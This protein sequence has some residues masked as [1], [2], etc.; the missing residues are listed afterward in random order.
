MV[1]PQKSRYSS[2][3]PQG[4]APGVILIDFEQRMLL[5]IPPEGCCV[6]VDLPHCAGIIVLILIIALL[7]RTVLRP[8]TRMTRHARTI[9]RSDDLTSRLDLKRADE[10]GELAGEFD[11]MVDSLAS[12]RR[13]LA[14]RSFD[15]GI[16]ENASGVLHNLGN[17]MTPLGVK[18]AMLQE[19]LRAAPAADVDLVLRELELV[20]Q[21]RSV[22][23]IWRRCCD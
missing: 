9:G 2:A 16:A 23:P 4:A 11:R 19:T 14:D 13:R 20:A 22:W 7:N 15:A 10:F 12:V 21:D 5:R 6:W 8:L 3:V 18:V 17:A 1:G